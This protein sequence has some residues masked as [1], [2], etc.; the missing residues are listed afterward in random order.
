MTFENRFACLVIS[1]CS[2]RGKEAKMSYFVPM[3]TGIAV[4][5]SVI[6]YLRT[7]LVEPSSLSVP[8]LDAV[9]SRFTCQVE[10][11]KDG[12]RVV[13]NEREHGYELPLSA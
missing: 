10:H 3:R 1:S 12:N 9:Q 2:S 6:P 5:I 7:H 8:F 13:G 4:W 11:E